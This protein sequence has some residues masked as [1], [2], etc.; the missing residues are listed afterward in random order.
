M[1]HSA[2]QALTRTIACEDSPVCR[3]QGWDDRRKAGR[4]L[5]GQ[6]EEE[7]WP[8]SLSISP[9]AMKSHSKRI[10]LQMR[11]R[12][13]G[14]VGSSNANRPEPKTSLG[15]ILDELNLPAQIKHPILHL[16]FTIRYRSYLCC[17]FASVFSEHTSFVF[18]QHLLGNFFF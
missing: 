3:D 18:S 6:S 4:A 11:R 12:A 15:L 1:F 13:G 7:A 8:G 14:Q 10:K 2:F 17:V 5:S 16:T 9:T